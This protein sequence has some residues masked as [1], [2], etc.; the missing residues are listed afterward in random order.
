MADFESNL[1]PFEVIEDEVVSPRTGIEVFVCSLDDPANVIDILPRRLAPTFVSEVGRPGSGTV[2]LMKSDPVFLDYPSILEHRNIVKA[3]VDQKVVGAFVIQGD[4]DIIVGKGEAAAE[5]ITVHGEGLRTWFNDAIVHPYRGIKKNSSPERVFSFASE[6]GSWYDASDWVPATNVAQYSLEPDNGSPWNTAPAEWPDAPAAHWIWDRSDT[7]PPIGFCYF[8]YEFDIA[9]GIGTKDYSVFTS[10]DDDFEVYIDSGRII[11]TKELNGWS[12]TWRADFTLDPGHHVLAARVKNNG[13]AGGFISALFR[14]GDA[15][16]DPPIAAQLLNVTGDAGWVVNGYPDPAPG[17]SP[18]EVMLTLLADAAENNVRMATTLVPTFTA[19]HD[20]DG[21]AW[22][23]PLDWAFDLGAKLTVVV[24]KLEELVCDVWINPENYE[25]NMAVE[26]G[27]HRDTQSTGLQPVKLEIGRNLLKAE[28]ETT[29]EMVNALMMSVA[30]GFEYHTDSLSDS[31]EKYGRLEGFVSGGSSASVSGDVAQ[32]VFDKNALPQES[33]TFKIVDVDDARPWRDFYEGDWLLAPSRTGLVPRRV[34]SMA[35]TEN[36]TGQPDFEIEFDSIVEDKN[37]RIERWLKTTSDGTLGGSVANSGGGSGTPTPSIPLS[38][39]GEAGQDGDQGPAGPPG[40]NWR[41]VWSN[42]TT[43]AVR[44]AVEYLGSS[45]IAMEAHS[46]ETPGDGIP[47]WDLI[48]QG[49]GIVILGALANTGLLPSTGNVKGDAYLVSG[50]LWIWGGTS[51]ANGGPVQGP[52]GETGDTGPQGDSAYQVW[53]DEGNVGSEAAFLLDIKGE[54]GDQGEQGETGPGLIILGELANTGLLPSTGNTPGDAYIISGDLWVYSASG[55]WQNVGDLSGP[56]GETGEQGEQGEQGET[57]DTGATGQSAYQ[58][59]LALGNSGTLADFIEDLKG[60]TG[61][62]AYQAW[63]GEGNTGTEADFLE[64]IKGETGDVGPAGASLV[65]LG[66]FSDELSLPGSGSAGDAY[67]VAGDLYI[68]STLLSDWE[69]VGPLTGGSGGGGGGFAAG[70][71][72]KTTGSIDPLAVEVGT[73]AMN[74]A[75]VQQVLNVAADRRSRIRFYASTA[76]RDADVASLRAP[77]QDPI[78]NHGVLMDVVLDSG[79]LSLIQS[80]SPT[81]FN[82]AGFPG[83]FPYAITNLDP[84]YTG[85]ITVTVTA[86]GMPGSAEGGSDVTDYVKTTASI[87]NNVSEQS[88]FALSSAEIHA[89]LLI[90][91]DKA[92]RVRFYAT[93]AQQAADLS[94]V[95]GQDATG[96]H[97][98]LFEVILTA[99]QL[100]RVNSPPTILFESTAF[101]PVPVTITNMSGSTGAV[102]VTLTA[103]GV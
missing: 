81:L 86:K 92:C 103:K 80:P 94:R 64:D 42:V 18:G 72:V 58:A 10:G 6:Q 46:G 51:W 55:G 102:A 76:F 2:T 49:A 100:S 48:A 99:G 33:A 90:A 28:N 14:V 93:A 70:N 101:G 3:R 21:V 15:T 27:S 95:I 67:M 4:Q 1:I 59:W 13:G 7:A 84:S 9:E 32:A 47:E 17:W 75:E 91:A 89:G 26:R 24:E 8:R 22:P 44:D 71:F 57:G 39:R 83:S 78:G 79:V 53:L 96:N 65:I 50:N 82:I 97:G 43:Y 38:P 52:Q 36:R 73:F 20:S 19:T 69:N 5:A 85:P 62:S 41:G 23:K 74:G 61:D 11:E 45:W 34:M 35:F 56:Q 12:K 88:T 87:A 16:A 66:T 31:E 68:W 60:E 40:I 63:L 25:L 37:E 30:D 54:Q 77:S 29:A 98:L